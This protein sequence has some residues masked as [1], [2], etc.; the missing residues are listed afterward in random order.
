MEYRGFKCILFFNIFINSIFISEQNKE[1]VLLDMSAS[2]SELG[3]L[4]W[5]DE[6]G[7]EMAQTVVN[8]SLHYNYFVCNVE[9]PAGQDNWLRTTFIQRQPT[10]TRVFVELRFVVRDCNSFN[11]ASLTCK[12]TFNLYA[13][14]SDVDIGTSFRK[15]HFRKV[16]T[17]APDE[18]SRVGELKINTETRVVENLSRKGFYL[19]FQDIGACV[20]LYSVRVYYKICPATIKSLA[21]FPE[22]VAGGDKQN[23]RKVAGECV[24]NAV[25]EDQP[26]IYC[27]VDGEWVVPVGQCQCRAGYAAAGDVC[28]GCQPGFF[29]A[30][31]SSEACQQCPANTQPSEAG[32][33]ICPCQDGYY[34]A[35]TD[36]PS[37][38]CSGLPSEPVDLAVTTV[39]STVGKVTMSWSPPE[40][41]GG[42][43]DLTYHVTCE[44]CDD[45]GCVPCEDRV[46]YEPGS[47]DLTD[48]S[49]LVS[50]LEPSVNYTF[51]VEARSGVSQFSNQR[52]LSSITTS[53][54][55]TDP[56]KVTTMQLDERSSN[57]L[58]LSWTVSRKAAHNRYQLMYRKKDGEGE[59]FSSGTT[60]TVLILENNWVQIGELAPATAYL[61]R[62]QAVNVDNSPVSDIMEHEF[63]TTAEAPNQGNTSVILGAAVGGGAMLLI[64]V[65]VLLIRKRRRGSHTR[66]GPEDTYFSPEQLKPLKTYVDP[67]TYED[68]NTA[69]HK[70]TKEIHPSH[71][72]KQKVIGAG[73]FGEVY[74][75]ILKVPG[76]KD[77]AVAVKTLKPGYSEKQRQD[78]LSEASIMGQFT[79]QNIIRLE[80]VVTKF[81]H[82]MIVTEYME[83]GA[84]DKY[85]KDHD[86][87]M[88][89]TQLVGMLRGISAGMK[90]LSDM[91]YV[92]RDLAARNILVNCNMECK[93]SDFGLSRVLEDDPEG[94]YTTSGGKIPIRW[95]APEAI[96]YRK[97]TS[98]SDVWSFGIVMWEVMAF[99]ERPY[100]DMSN[101]EVMKAI[102]EAF[103]LPAPMDCPSAVYQLMLQCWQHDRSKRPRFPDIVSI[104]D[105]LL[106][107]PESL[108]AIADF[109]PRVSIRLPSTSGSDGSPFRSVSEWLE[110]IKMSQYSE[111]FSCAGVVSMEQVL[112]MKSEDIRNIGVRLPGHLKRIAYSI[113]GLKDQTSTLSV[114]AV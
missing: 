30:D 2:G 43:S 103:R 26:L 90:Y 76:R 91:S 52:A 107:S 79:H 41:A 36:L 3:W 85:L 63:T 93:V 75:G 68:P 14:D 47:T 106:K 50:Q 80:G 1:E 53:L 100:W 114:F 37:A 5:P 28:Q 21:A 86:G 99:G 7:W 102:N 20:A 77:L 88:S 96:A 13:S 11:G 97:F 24:E 18:I 33:L 92:H 95:T 111:N 16:A 45:S 54:H 78:F 6:D 59:T 40:D 48:T 105:K 12:E 25:S 9:S 89:S 17:I 83:N 62:V 10:A 110:S 56:L 94:T 31:V 87:E 61:F 69:V 4:K 51:S 29:K 58:S 70:F 74:R 82:A 108:K 84:L 22:T 113:L 65:V 67:H 23:L 44:R 98:A 72:T 15:N 49:V 27:T 71:V 8:G 112:Q 101:H 104:L 60:Y 73:E 34:R 39:P 46:R 81:K 19:A 42:R 109:D 32:A 57:S 64:V 35:P 66:Q 38:G 55:Y